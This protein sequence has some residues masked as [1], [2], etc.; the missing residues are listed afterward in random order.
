[1]LTS[2]SYIY[3]ARAR[4]QRPVAPSGAQE[5]PASRAPRTK[6]VPAAGVAVQPSDLLGRDGF[7]VAKTKEKKNNT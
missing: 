5:L 7:S 3:P 4:D 1:M 6:H 2:T